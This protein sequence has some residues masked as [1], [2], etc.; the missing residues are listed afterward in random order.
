MFALRLPRGLPIG[1]LFTVDN[2]Q[3]IAYAK[4]I[5]VSGAGGQD[6]A[7]SRQDLALKAKYTVL[8]NSPPFDPKS[9]GVRALFMLCE[10][11]RR[12]RFQAFLIAPPDDFPPALRKLLIP[13]GRL[14]LTFRT[15]IVVYSEVQPANVREANHVVRFLL[16]KPGVA[17]TNVASTYG[18]HDFFVHFDANHVPEGRQSQD[19]YT[20]LVDRQFYHREGEATDRQG[21]VL[22]TKRHTTP[23]IAI[24]DHLRPLTVVSPPNTMTHDQLGDLY[25]RS[26]AFIAFE[27]TTAIYEALSCGCPVICFATDVFNRSTFQPRFGGAGLTWDFTPEAIAQAMSTVGRFNE[28]YEAIERDYP[29]RVEAVFLNILREAAARDAVRSLR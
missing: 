10:T 24:P 20:P 5:S 22:C 15:D 9:G 29:A 8:V 16:N 19:L 26:R 21:Y 12:L 17:M 6:M 14:H 25:R 4:A 2:P 7:V 13:Q 18:P 27:R 1:E 11:L 3:P 23:P 28:I